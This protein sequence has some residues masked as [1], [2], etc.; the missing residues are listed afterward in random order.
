MGSRVVWE[1]LIAVD[2]ELIL[3]AV[4][5]FTIGGIDDLAIDGIWLARAAW[6]RLVI[7][8]FHDRVDT[9]TLADP[10]RPG[11]LAVFIAAWHEDDVIGGMLS[12]ANR[13]WQGLDYRIYFGVYPNDAATQAAVRPFV[14]PN[15][16]MVVCANPG[17]TTKADCLNNLCG[18]M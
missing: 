15:V 9:R 18:I 3:F 8:K 14:G 11:R 6:R 16:R 12:H 7:Y 10:M 2:R 17:P 1:I 4:V 5:G 13:A